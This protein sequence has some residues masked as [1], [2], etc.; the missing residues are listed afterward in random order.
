MARINKTK[1]LFEQAL[2]FSLNDKF[3]QFFRKDLADYV[4]MNPAPPIKGRFF[5]GLSF[6]F[7]V[8][9]ATAAVMIF[10][11]LSG[12]VGA[13]ASPKSV[14]GDML[15]PIK[16]AQERLRAVFIQA[17]KPKADFRIKQAYTRVNEIKDLQKRTDQ[18]AKKTEDKNADLVEAT[19]RQ[20]SAHLENALGQTRSLKEKNKLQEAS[21]VNE[22]LAMSLKFYKKILE[23]EAEKKEPEISG[24]GDM[25]K[26]K[27]SFE[28]N[29]I[30]KATED[31]QTKAA[32]EQAEVKKQEA[33]NFSPKNDEILEKITS[34]AG[35]IEEIEA[36]IQARATSQAVISQAKDDLEKARSRLGEAREKFAKADINGAFDKTQDVFEITRKVRAFIETALMIEQEKPDEALSQIKDILLDETE[37]QSENKG[38]DK[39]ED[40]QKEPDQGSNK[41]RDEN[42]NKN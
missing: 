17:G 18:T 33:D 31:F 13:F 14:P 3:L 38:K 34:A 30:I 41:G 24:P 36:L 29:T 6:S 12:W 37:S 15:Y 4:K 27:K 28:I 7:G 1:A 2:K 23:K 16:I 20:F 10:I 32:K 5:R 22:R 25:N 39:T 21:E 8:V 42:R 35:A 40:R 26:T 9:P 11:L 19:S